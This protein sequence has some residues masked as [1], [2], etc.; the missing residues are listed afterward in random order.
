[1]TIKSLYIMKHYIK[2][3]LAG[4]AFM[5]IVLTMFFKLNILMVLP[6]LLAFQIMDNA[7]ESIKKERNGKTSL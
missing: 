3:I 2:F 7:Y 4:L 1:M 5:A 6:A